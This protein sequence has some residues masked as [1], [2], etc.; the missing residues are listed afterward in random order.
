MLDGFTLTAAVM[1]AMFVVG[2]V[3]T[4]RPPTKRRHKSAALKV[5][6]REGGGA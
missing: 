4:A 5:P 2:F 6:M 1:V 3:L